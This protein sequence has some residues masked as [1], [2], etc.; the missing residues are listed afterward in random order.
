MALNR[1]LFYPGFCLCAL[2]LMAAPAMAHGD[3]SGTPAA[4]PE[5]SSAGLSCRSWGR[6]A[7]GELA[8]HGHPDIARL[9]DGRQALSWRGGGVRASIMFPASRRTT[10]TLTLNAEPTSLSH[11]LS[12]SPRQPL[13]TPMTDG[14]FMVRW[15][16]ER[17][18]ER[19]RPLDAELRARRVNL[20]CDT[21]QSNAEQVLWRHSGPVQSHSS[22]VELIGRHDQAGPRPLVLAVEHETRLHLLTRGA[23][24]G[25]IIALPARRGSHTQVIPASNGGAHVIWVDGGR[26][27]RLA[28]INSNGVLSETVATLTG[29]GALTDAIIKAVETRSGHIALVWAVDNRILTA[30]ATPDGVLLA[31]PT[32]VNAVT[33]QSRTDPAI[34]AT[35]DGGFV[36]SWTD[37][38][39]Y[40][41]WA[42]TN[43]Q[44]VLRRLDARGAIVGD[45]TELHRIGTSPGHRASALSADWEGRVYLAHYAGTGLSSQSRVE[46]VVCTLTDQEGHGS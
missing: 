42:N 38:R 6:F 43:P 10:R 45:E 19:G 30:L 41:S 24:P 26:T 34:V 39:H 11:T 46:I 28:Q 14:G 1:V 17:V 12:G 36:V 21:G 22:L 20:D 31:G 2:L 9:S 4:A 13:I 15:W 35:P 33:I 18:D 37:F 8:G 25:E 44:I 27:M 7:R 5:A 29:M 32:Q 3:G 16:H 40:R 23:E